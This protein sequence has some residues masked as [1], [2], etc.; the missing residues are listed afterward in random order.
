MS[1]G[2]PFGAL[3]LPLP[4]GVS[5]EEVLGSLSPQQRATLGG[6]QAA[7]APS[8]AVPPSLLG[9]QPPQMPEPSPSA[10]ALPSLVGQPMPAMPQGA[11]P[12]MPRPPTAPS[13]EEA[14]NPTANA[15]PAQGQ[16]P[17]SLAPPGTPLAPTPASPT[18]AA[19]SAAPE[20]GLGEVLK[21]M[22][23]SGF[24][25]QMLALSAGL[26]SGRGASGWAKGLAGMSKAAETGATLDIA[27]QKQALENLKAQREQRTLTGNAQYVMGKI[28]GITADQA[29]TLGSNST[30]MNELFKG[31]LPPTE[32]FKQYTDGNGNI[33]NQNARTGQATV[34]LKADE[35]KTQRPL[36]D[37]AERAKFGIAADDSK[38]Y[39]VD[40]NNKVSAI[41]G[42][43]TSVSVDLGKKAA[44]EADAQI[45]KKIDTSY[46]KAQGALGTLAA[47]GRQKQAID[48]GII[49]GWG[50]DWQTQARA[51]AGKLLGLSD[52]D[53]TN[54]QAFE[55]AA[56]SKSAELAKAIS[57]AGHTTNMDLQLGKTIAGGDRSKTEA[58]IRQII[59]AQELLAK[60]TIA[61]HNS[62]VDRYVG[63]SP[64]MKDRMGWYHVETPDVYRYGQ[65]TP[66]PVADPGSAPPPMT[67]MIGGKTYSK[68]PDGHW[69]EGK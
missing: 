34:A 23:D 11:A 49:S 3:A 55:G 50:A 24:G 5:L 63:A 18:G 52:E 66:N 15:V 58:A 44:G 10:P 57:Q 60:D 17:L 7:P 14:D 67:R 13:E 42:G 45:L 6:S 12:A 27:R 40:A 51:M 68:G 29:V 21:R 1:A 65:G 64:D 53:V 16:A 8:P 38:P 61:H 48:R 28:P 37:P 56:A 26:L 39:Q 62:G 31:V 69:Y 30:F 19:K 59:D 20:T 41:G 36:T 4:P 35:D 9:A 25:D 22:G 47:I 46:D 32:L 43:G 2:S 54:S 33:W